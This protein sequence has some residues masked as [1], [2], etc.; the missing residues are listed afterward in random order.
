MKL[1]RLKNST[2]TEEYRYLIIVME[3]S[4][5]TSVRLYEPEYDPG[6]SLSTVMDWSIDPDTLNRALEQMA[7]AMSAI[8]SNPQT[9]LF[10][11]YELVG[12]R[13]EDQINSSKVAQDPNETDEA[14]PPFSYSAHGLSHPTKRTTAN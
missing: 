3:S 6:S 13:P 8:D 7:I 11:K 14:D 1:Y 5:S 4:N 10:V 2:E 12:L 9:N